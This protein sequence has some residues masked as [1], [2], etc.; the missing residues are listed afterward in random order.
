MSS[1]RF[2]F[3]SRYEMSNCLFEATLQKIEEDCGCTPKY[4]VDLIEGFQACE[5]VQKQCMNRRMESIG[6][7]RIV[8]DAGILKVGLINKT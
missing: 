7:Q 1:L 6:E 4:F 8:S 2:H 5:G 3:L